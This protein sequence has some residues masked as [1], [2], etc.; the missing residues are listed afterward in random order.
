M[1]L[2]A[3]AA[4]PVAPTPEASFPRFTMSGEIG[5]CPSRFSLSYWPAQGTNPD[6]NNDSWICVVSW[7]SPQGEKMSTL[8]D[9][10]LPATQ[11]GSCPGN[12]TTYDYELT[13]MDM[14]D[15]RDRNK[16][17][18]LCRSSTADVNGEYLF[19]DDNMRGS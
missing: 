10:N 4:E 8:I 5:G 9:N 17:Q 18:R 3:C 2:A 13:G 6:R 12:F 11:V 19:I 14:Y 1:T 15:P 16:N 7:Q